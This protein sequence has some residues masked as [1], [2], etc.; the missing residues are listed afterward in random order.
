LE[1]NKTSQETGPEKD[2]IDATKIIQMIQEKQKE[3]ESAKEIDEFLLRQRIER[4]LKYEFNQMQ[5][6]HE[7]KLRM[8]YR[9]MIEQMYLDMLN[10]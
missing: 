3:N 9:K 7:K 6:D 10:S 8:V 1:A 2:F 4:E 5:I